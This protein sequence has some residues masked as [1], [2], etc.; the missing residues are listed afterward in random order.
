MKSACAD[1]TLL[2]SFSENHDQPRFASKT[3]D[4]SLAKNVIGFTILADGIPIIYAGQEQHYSGGDVPN[5]REA[6]WLSGYNTGATLYTWTAALNKIRKQAI[7]KDSAYLTYK[8]YPVYSDESTIV[9][10]KG[11]TGNQIIAVFSNQGSS[12]SSYTLTLTPS[13]TGFTA[14]QAL[15]EVIGCTSYTTDSTGNLFV[16]MASGVPRVFYPRAQLTG[17]GICSS[18]T[19]QHNGHADL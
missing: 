11:F 6:T 19:G 2:G 7:S 14:N 9:M 8:A 13:Q 3:S 10:R 5:D 16:G 12:G 17:S 4:I 1:T 18:I 15:V